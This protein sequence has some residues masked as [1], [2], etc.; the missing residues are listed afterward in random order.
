[1]KQLVDCGVLLPRRQ[2]QLTTEQFKK[3]LEY[4]MTIKEKNDG[5]IKG[6][7]CADGRKQQECIP[8][9]DASFPTPAPESVY[10][11]C[12]I[13]TKIIGLL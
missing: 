4:I 6:R 8:K 3:V 10:I 12:D 11:S 7:G 2:K 13:D 1:M 5:T 9:E